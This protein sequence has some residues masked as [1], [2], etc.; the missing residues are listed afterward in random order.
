MEHT[1]TLGAPPVTWTRVGAGFHVASRPGEYVGFVERTPAGAYAA[2]DAFSTRIAV[3]ETLEDARAA[4]LAPGTAAHARVAG[5][6]I[7]PGI[8]LRRAWREMSSALAR[9]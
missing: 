2:F 3:L 9:Q 6:A 1:A 5:E 4:V 8:G 7:R